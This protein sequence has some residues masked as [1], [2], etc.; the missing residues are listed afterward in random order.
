MVVS[1]VVNAVSGEKIEDAPAIRGEKFRSEASFIRDVHF[2][3]VQQRYPLR[4][5]VIGIRR[6]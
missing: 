4:V 2:Q 6:R 5:H 1:D 3:D